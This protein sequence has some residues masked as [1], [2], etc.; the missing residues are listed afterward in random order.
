MP[1][2]RLMTWN[3]LFGVVATRLGAWPMR[4]PLARD[5]IL[6]AAPDVVAVQEID[7]TQLDWATHGVPGYAALVGQPTGVSSYPRHVYVLAPVLL[8]T[9]VSLVRI[10]GPAPW[11]AVRGVLA[12][13]CIA[14]AVLGPLVVFALERY[15]GPFAAPGEFAPIL[16]RPDRLRPLGEGTLWI[17]PTP[18]QPG[19]S[20]P[21]LFEPR[22]LRWAR[23]AFVDESASTFLVVPVHLGHAPWSYADS[24]R[25]ILATIAARRAT[26][27]EPVF[28]LGDFNAIAAADVVKRL[29]APRGPLANAVTAS[30]GR[31]GPATTFQWN[32]AP[33]APALDLDHVLYAGPARPTRARVLTPRI[34]GHTISD[35][36]PL[37]VE[38]ELGPTS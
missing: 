31:E 14:G 37:V 13:L 34:G 32:L 18:D 15:R 10:P 19:T 4:G 17:S 33:G 27:D 12:G 25:L 5:V 35:H 38:F 8:V 23:F 26:P 16:Y 6:D 36:D 3:V 9:A 1:R 7:S 28:V 24:A 2:L 29:V 30:P 22:I 21:L 11:L 20:F